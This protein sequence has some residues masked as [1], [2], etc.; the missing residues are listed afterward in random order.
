MEASG[1]G[2]V[3]IKFYLFKKKKSG[4]VNLAMGYRFFTPSLGY[5][6]DVSVRIL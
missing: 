5:L 4:K 6:S 1:G 3:P 2:C